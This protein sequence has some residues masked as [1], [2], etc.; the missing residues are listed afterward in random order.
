[1]YNDTLVNTTTIFD[2]FQVIN[3]ATGY[4]NFFAI[5]I[6]FS[7][8]FIFFIASITVFD[9]VKSITFS[10]FIISILSALFW[11]MGELNEK[12]IIVPVIIFIIGIFFII[13]GER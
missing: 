10:S 12:Y 13:F 2:N 4:A 7:L 1:M 3:N 8:W 11:A 5:I 9:Y 6:L